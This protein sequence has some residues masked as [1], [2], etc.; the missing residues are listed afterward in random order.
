M[1]HLAIVEVDEAGTAADWGEHVT[2]A[3]YAGAP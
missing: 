1:L 2:D 3:E